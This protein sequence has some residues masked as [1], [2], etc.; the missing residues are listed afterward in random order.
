MSLA[1]GPG[2]YLV[3]PATF[4]PRA[5]AE[6]LGPALDA[7]EIVCVRLDHAGP[8]DEIRA[9]ADAL[10]PVCLDRGVSLVVAEHVALARE[11]G[12][13]GVHLSLGAAGA[14]RKARAALGADAVIGAWGG[15]S[16][17]WGMT[18]AEAGAD[19][20]SLGPVAPGALG[21]GSRA[22]LDLFR[23]WAEMIETPVVAE[24]GISPTDAAMLAP[25]VDFIALREE[26][27]DAAEGEVAALA[28][29]TAA[30]KLEAR[31]P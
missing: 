28:G 7:A 29:F 14:V 1:Q 2:L 26:V 21:D 10:R 20:V 25:F 23:W 8:E 6:R 27:W 4:P 12:L 11:H 30:V 18:A 17:H 19:Y 13:D 22:D 31:D 9:A 3:T 16:R 15:A 5:F 24:G